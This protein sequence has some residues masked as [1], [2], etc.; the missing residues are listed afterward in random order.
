MIFNSLSGILVLVPEKVFSGRDSPG[1]ELDAI[2]T[3]GTNL[4]SKPIPDSM[5][6][7]SLDIELP[8]LNYPVLND[9]EWNFNL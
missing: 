8:N 3:P 6:H 4:S 1:I 7:D 9:R 5:W 2:P